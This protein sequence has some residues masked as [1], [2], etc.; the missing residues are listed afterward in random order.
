MHSL[1]VTTRKFEFFL[2]SISP[3]PASK[4]PVTVSSS[5]MRHMRASFFLAWNP[6]AIFD[7]LAARGTKRKKEWGTQERGIGQAT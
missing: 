3:I 1:L 7:Y 5:P 4:N 2:A 6:A